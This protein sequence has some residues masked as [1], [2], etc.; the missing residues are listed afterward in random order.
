MR[1]TS[2][3]QPAFAHQQAVN[4]QTFEQLIRQ[5]GGGFLALAVLHEFNAVHQAHAAHV[6]DDRVLLLQR[7]Q[8]RVEV[9]A[10]AFSAL[11]ISR[12]SSIKSIA[13]L[14][15]TQATGFPPKVEMV[16]PL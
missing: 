1:T 14:A 16:R 10:V 5:I 13:A 8:A 11:S 15:A 4:P 3:V 2:L 7:F 9:I 6:A 12:S